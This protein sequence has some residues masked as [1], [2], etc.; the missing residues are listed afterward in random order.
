[1]AGFCVTVDLKLIDYRVIC[2]AEMY[3]LHLLDYEH[4]MC[5]SAY[6]T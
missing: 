6:I 5:K 3:L 4:A 1:M 2:S